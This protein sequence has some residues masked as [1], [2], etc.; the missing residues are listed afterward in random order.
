MPD[1][2]FYRL[3]VIVIHF[4]NRFFLR[5]LCLCPQN[6]FIK[7]HF[8]NSRT[9]ICLIRDLFCQNIRRSRKG[10][11]NI[12]HILC[13]ISCSHFGKR[14]FYQLGSD[15]LGQWLQSPFSGDHG[16]GTPFRTI[17]TIQILHGHHGLR[18]FD[19]L[20]QFRCH[21]FLALDGRDDL[22]FLSLQISQICQSFTKISQHF[23][24]Q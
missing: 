20:F 15:D 14:L 19:L 5:L 9:I 23:I 6:T 21:L 8:S 11:L 3:T 16:A 17:R 1:H 18:L 2:P 10:S 13:D 24:V 4:V 7:C 22:G 12:R